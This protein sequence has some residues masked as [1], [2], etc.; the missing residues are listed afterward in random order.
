[1][2]NIGLSDIH[3]F[4]KEEREAWIAYDAEAKHRPEVCPVCGY[5]R[6]H[7]H[8]HKVN[9]IRDIAEGDPRVSIPKLVFI[10]LRIYR[11]RCVECNAVFP[12]EFSFYPKRGHITYRLRKEF[13]ALWQDGYSISDIAWVYEVDRK[14]VSA[15][16]GEV[17]DDEQA[18]E[19]A[20]VWQRHTDTSGNSWHTCPECGYITHTITQYC[21]DC[22][23]R[24]RGT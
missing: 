18:M 2:D 23:E 24:L 4:A 16:I 7:I 22:G 6:L 10:R 21:P 9:T 19:I 1:M 11:Y 8:S 20:K 17:R 5:D 3:V 13:K 15:A 12:D 14:T